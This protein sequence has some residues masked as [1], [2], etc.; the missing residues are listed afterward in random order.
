MGR[1]LGID[2]GK[3]RVGLAISDPLGMFASG[4]E[5]L[6]N[7]SEK[8]LLADLQ[9]VIQEHNI[10][11]IILGLPL[12]STGEFGEAAETVQGFGEK[13]SQVT[14][15]EVG[16]EDERFTSV[17]AQQ[18]LKA[19]GVQ[20]SRQKHLTD[21]TAAALILQQYLDKRARETSE[22]SAF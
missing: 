10:E 3:R 22:N 8:R 2:Y 15:L 4:L 6:D 20:P 14:G 12:K 5:T 7:R 19:Q 9:Q 21:K 18:S 13:L 17:I 11:K 16:Y 1:L